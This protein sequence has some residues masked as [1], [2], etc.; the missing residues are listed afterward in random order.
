MIKILDKFRKLT[1]PFRD[2]FIKKEIKLLGLEVEKSKINEDGT[3]DYIG[4][5]D[6]RNKDLKVIPIQFGTVEGIFD[7]SENEL[8]SLKNSPHTIIGDFKCSK[9]NLTNL[10]YSPKVINGSFYCNQ[11]KLKSLIDCPKELSYSFDCSLNLLETLEHCP[12]IVGKTFSANCNKINTLEYFPE[13]VGGIAYLFYNEVYNLDTLK[14]CFI[15]S[16]LL[17]GD[18]NKKSIKNSDIDFHFKQKEIKEQKEKLTSELKANEI[19][20]KKRNKL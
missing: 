2:Y 13:Y 20:V 17:I 11:N 10:K 7:C 19:V 16:E 14:K 1:H 12:T 18:K 8:T 3:V 9:N 15:G 4:F 6:L 5:V